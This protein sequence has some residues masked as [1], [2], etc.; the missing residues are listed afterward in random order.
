MTSENMT[1]IVCPVGCRLNVTLDDNGSICEVS[2][3][4][5]KRGKTMSK[6]K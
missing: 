3:N 2:G 6:P 5:C 1:C 4:N